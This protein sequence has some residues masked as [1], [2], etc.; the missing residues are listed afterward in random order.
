M[1]VTIFPPCSTRQSREEV[2]EGVKM[3]SAAGLEYI[4]YRPWPCAGARSPLSSSSLTG[5]F[6][7]LSD[8]WFGARRLRRLF[9]GQGRFIEERAVAAAGEEREHQRER[10]REREE[11]EE[12][13][14]EILRRL[15]LRAAAE[16]EKKKRPP[17][18]LSLCEREHFASC[19]CRL[20]KKRRESS[21]VEREWHTKGRKRKT[22]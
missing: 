6:R 14:R 12:R 3:K 20:K 13:E 2:G 8:S 18:T 16:R 22:C 7:S 1:C 19:C 10:E 15:R 11:R 21:P 17:K 5:G 9:E 4:Y